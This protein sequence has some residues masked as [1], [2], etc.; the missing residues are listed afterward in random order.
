ME[1]LGASL[2][3]PKLSGPAEGGTSFADTLAA[4]LKEVNGLQH[5]ADRAIE[6]LITGKSKSIHDT[7]ITL[8]KAELAFKMTMQI[9]NKVIEGYKEVMNTSL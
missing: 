5:D 4:S 8:S 9:K 3:L 6:D 7:M 1:P 2:K